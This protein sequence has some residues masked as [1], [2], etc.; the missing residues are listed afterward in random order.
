MSG[1][2][3][4]HCG[5]LRA[6]DEGRELELYGWVARRRDHG[7]LIFIDLRDRWGAVQVVFNPAH[8]PQAHERASDL[9]SEYVVRV[10][11]KVARRRPG[12]ANPRMPTGEV[13]VIASDLEVI[14]TAKTPPFAIEDDVEADEATRL[15][16]RYLD[17][18]RPKMTHNLELRHRVVQA[19]HRYMDSREFIEVETPMLVK[20]TPEGS[21]DFIVPSR[22]HPGEFFALPQSPQQM[23]QLLMVAGIGRYYQIARCLRDE[24]LRADRV[25]EIT[26]LDVEMSFCTEEDVLALIEGLWS[27][28]WKDVLGIDI[29]TPFRRIDM[30]ESLLKYGTDKPD[31]RYDLEIADVSDA[32]RDTGATVLRSALDAGGVVRCLAVPGGKDMSRRELDELAVLAKGAGAKGLA[33][34]P[35]P[36]DRHL[37]EGEMSAIKAAARA[38]GDDLVLIVADR[39]R[40]AETVMGLLRREIA[41]RRK[42][43]RQG[44]WNFLW[45]YPM[46]LFQEDD[47][48][49]LTYGHHPFTSPWPEDMALLESRPYDVRARAYDCVLN[50]VE[51]S[52]GS[53]RIHDR[54]LQEKVFEILGMDRERISSQFGHLLDAFEYGVPPHGG[55][56]AGIDRLMMA[57]KDTENI[58]DVVAFPKTQSHQDLML[59]APSPVDPQQ[60]EELHIQVAP[61]KK[62]VS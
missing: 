39:R 36:L 49:N 53:I 60:L 33:W 48:G 52:G 45:V 2:T 54:G 16:Y 58:R 32:L 3:A 47:L 59:G 41:R 6:S 61:R 55:I 42:L 62:P 17:I 56:A 22:L 12:A 1:F 20:G 30:Q 14:S 25:V 37:G 44:E 50:G 46:Y 5:S 43:A 35:G 19:I 21:R 31:L 8:A 26:Q 27:Q 38:G 4:P 11:G 34:I 40:K 24:D 15:K 57:I 28:V 9:R 23:K 10:G 51:I 18:R 29:Q 7:G 13:E